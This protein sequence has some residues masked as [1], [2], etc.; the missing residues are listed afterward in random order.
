MVDPNFK[1]T[2]TS[3]RNAEEKSTDGDKRISQEIEDSVSFDYLKF[4]WT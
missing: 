1:K 3:K 4:Q 2:T